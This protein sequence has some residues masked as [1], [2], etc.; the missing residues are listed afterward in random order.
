MQLK[1]Y[2]QDLIDQNEITVGAQTFPNLGLE[3]YQNLFP[4]HNKNTSKTP[5][6]NNTLNN[7]KQ[8]NNTQK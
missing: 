7:K 2:V 3:I 1:H 6:Q 4:S 5:M 8:T